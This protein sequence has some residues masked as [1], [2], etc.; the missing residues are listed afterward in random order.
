MTLE[1]ALAR[2]DELE[3]ARY[4]YGHAMSVLYVDG[5]TVAPKQ[6]VIGRG[7]TLAYLSEAAYGLLVNDEVKEALETILA[8]GDQATPMQRR[9][10]ELLK[11]DYDD[12]TRI[13]VQEYVAFTTLCNDASAVWHEAKEKSDYTMFAPYLE[14][15]VA[16]RRRFAGY[17]DTA[18][19]AYDVLLDGYEKGMS[20]AV[21]DPFFQTLRERL[22]PVI[23]AVQGKPAPRADFLHGDFPVW[24]QR[25]LSE[26]VMAMMGLP[27]DRC[28]LG[29]T[30]HP[31]TDGINKWDVRIT[32][33]YD[34]ADVT[35]SLYSVI[36]EGG[37]ALY[38]LGVDD[39]CQFTCL[40]GVSMSIHESQSRFYENLI[41]RSL[42]FC[43]A[44][45]PVL[46]ELFPEKFAG[47]T[48]EA[49]YA[50][51]NLAR[52][53][54]IRTEADELTYSMHVMIRYELEKR[55]FTGDVTVGELPALWNQMYRDYL[56]VTV[57]NDREGILQDSHWSGASFGYFPSYA[58]GSAYGAQMLRA[59]EKDVDP[60]PAVAKGDLSP[61][62]AWLGE[63]LHR[64]G[65]L[66]TP[67]QL[68]DNAL[69]EPFD[70]TCYTDYLT[71]KFS[72]LYGL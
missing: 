17:K 49:L 70:P 64:H 21:L 8:A 36:H 1:Q 55:M 13:P 18:K 69:G 50:A 53:S 54:L 35:S 67:K 45:L 16:C 65:A 30:E 24:K 51:V 5:D 43:Q 7:K 6:S 4:A 3:A 56:G 58:L 37:H 9:R 26:R 33:H 14:K 60:W 40:T 2:M 44:L 29:E 11:E 34:P 20:T 57:P 63:K 71:R 12:T 59:M 52:P 38:E 72:A 48:A 28:I 62:T 32:T 25:L 46:A 23:L 27:R 66:Y 42:P 31:F 47:V 19:P 10:A 68:L 39:A 15:L 41:G 61:V 22:A